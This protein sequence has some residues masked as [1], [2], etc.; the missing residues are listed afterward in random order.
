MKRKMIF[1]FT[2]IEL[3]VVIS[4]I[5]ILISL[6]VFGLQ[7]ARTS[8]RDAKRKA[9][10]EAI[11]S[12]LEIYKADCG[13]YPPLGITAGSLRLLDSTSLVGLP[14]VAGCAGN[15]YISSVPRDPISTRNYDYKENPS[16][17]AT[18]RICAALEQ[19]P[20]PATD[21]SQLVNCSCGD[22]ACNYAVRNP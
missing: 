3:L 19:V 4:I 2:L 11:R 8:S 9:D 1:G 22:V 10:L 21:P 12:G 16:T 7:G 14:S 15:T 5:G 17:H 6:S 13:Q 18:Y 20:V